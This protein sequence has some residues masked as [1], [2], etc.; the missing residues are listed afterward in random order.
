MAVQSTRRRRTRSNGAPAV[1][2]ETEG[3]SVDSNASNDAKADDKLPS[4]ITHHRMIARNLNALLENQGEL[5]NQVVKI[6][7]EYKRNDKDLDARIFQ[8]RNQL[9]SLEKKID[10][11]IEEM[12]QI[13]FDSQLSMRTNS[14]HIA[15]LWEALA[16]SGDDAGKIDKLRTE[17]VKRAEKR[18]VDADQRLREL[19]EQLQGDSK[20]PTKSP[21]KSTRTAKQ[22]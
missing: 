6:E 2:P 8:L 13:A 4:H 18:E 21:T 16:D 20:T 15:A 7:R 12:T 10:E 9:G 19:V 5:R 3:T 14:D 11:F 17:A 22:K 1:E